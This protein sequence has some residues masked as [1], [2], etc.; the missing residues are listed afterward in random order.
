MKALIDCRAMEAMCRKRA[1]ADKA[2]RWKWL[3]RAKRWHDVGHQ[4][5]AYRFQERNSAR[6]TASPSTQ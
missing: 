2:Y 5:I 4:K 6:T 3:A 1:L